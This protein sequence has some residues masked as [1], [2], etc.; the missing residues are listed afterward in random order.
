MR[1]IGFDPGAHGAIALVENGQLLELHDMPAMRV[2]RGTRVVNEVNAAALGQLVA[3]LRAEAAVVEKVGAMPGQGVS[4]MFAFGRALGV[5]EGVLGALQVPYTKVPP[6][7]WQK[8][9]RVRGGKDGARERA[10]AL[11]PARAG[12]FARVKD[13]GRAD[14]ALLAAYGAGLLATL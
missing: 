6:Q 5:I 7:E 9:M 11:F 13:D 2:K 10:S 8:G 12:D 14:A 1:I 3:A 4:S